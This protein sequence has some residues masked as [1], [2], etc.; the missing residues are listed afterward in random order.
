MFEQKYRAAL[1]YLD[2]QL[3]LSTPR[4]HTPIRRLSSLLPS[5]AAIAVPAGLPLPAPGLRRMAEEE[6][7][8]SKLRYPNA[9]FLGGMYDGMFFLRVWQPGTGPGRS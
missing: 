6:K 2:K 9:N 3:E 8:D 7:V 1:A 5:A 4:S